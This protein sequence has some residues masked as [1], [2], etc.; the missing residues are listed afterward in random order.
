VARFKTFADPMMA[1]GRVRFPECA[2]CDF[3]DAKAT[4]ECLLSIIDSLEDGTT[5][6]IMVHPG[7]IDDEIMRTSTYNT[8]RQIELGVITDPHVLERVRSRGIELVTFR[9]L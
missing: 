5:S 6:E 4:V 7:M 9:Q 1:E 2:I 3:Y 8:M